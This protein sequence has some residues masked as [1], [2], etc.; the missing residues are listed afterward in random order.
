[1]ITIIILIILP[2]V[3][4]IWLSVNESKNA[5]VFGSLSLELIA[6][7]GGWISTISI[8]LLGFHFIDDAEGALGKA[9]GNIFYF[10]FFVLPT[11]VVY[12]G[13]YQ[14]AKECSKNRL[15]ILAA[16]VFLSPLLVVCI[17]GGVALFNNISQ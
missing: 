6:F 5:N 10:F 3:S 9:V 15:I 13:I 16:S 17:W 1:M 11:A 12:P 7:I 4:I 14:F 8:A 2:I